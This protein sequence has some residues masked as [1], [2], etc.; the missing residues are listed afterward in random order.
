MTVSQIRTKNISS[1]YLCGCSGRDFYVGLTDTLFGVPGSW[2]L[3]ECTN[4]SCGLA[5]LDPAPIPEDVGLLYKTYYTHHS[6]GVG[7][8]T[9]SDTGFGR[10]LI[11]SLY[12]LLIRVLS[13]R[14]R[15]KR[16]NVMYL[17]KEEPGRILDVGCG[18]GDRLLRFKNL[19]WEVEGQEIDSKATAFARENNSLLVHDGDL[20]S[21]ELPSSQY[22]AIILNHV[23]EHLVDPIETLAECLRLLKRG[24]VL[25]AATPNI[26][27]YGRRYYKEYWRGLEPPR[28]L[29]IFTPQALSAAAEKAGFVGCSAWTEPCKAEFFAR[30]SLQIEANLAVLNGVNK[31]VAD[32]F[33]PMMFQM[34]SLLAYRKDPDSGEECILWARKV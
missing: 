17:D 29:H 30:G 33:Q 14:K 31:S 11:H 20:I 2:T 13:V 15:R 1:C 26:R 27:S 21:L 25:V 22:D 24:G 16:L 34:K 3:K 7:N 23:V 6:K 32:I 8:S 18:N 12:K 28:H 4:E 9:G 10:R 19:G 5:W